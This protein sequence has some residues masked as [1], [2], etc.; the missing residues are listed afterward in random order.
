MLARILAVV[1]V[2]AAIGAA[3]WYFWP[4]ELPPPPPAATTPAPVTVPPV[5]EGP[6]HPIESIAEQPQL[7]PLK[8]SDPTMLQALGQLVGSAALQKFFNLEAMVPNIVATIDNLPRESYAQRLNPLKPI[9]GGFR[10]VGRDPNFAIAGDNDARYGAFVKMVESVDT[11]VATY[12]RMY[13]LFQQAYVELGYPNGYFND[14][15][16]EVID[17][18]LSTPEVQGPIPLVTPHV[19]YEY[20][21][22]EL[23][24]LSAGRKAML[25]AGPENMRRLKARLREIRAQVVAAEARR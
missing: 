18:L 3:T 4:R 21:N 1:A 7:P 15:L 22:A 8:E 23:E 14:R 20:A 2:V 6:K 16:V 19:L 12:R 13:P 9:E 17:H 5:V 10:V 25:R 24:A 11:A